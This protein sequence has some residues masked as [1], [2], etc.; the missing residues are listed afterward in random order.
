MSRVTILV[1]FVPSFHVLSYVTSF[2]ITI[3]LIVTHI[4]IMLFLFLSR[5]NIE[6]SSIYDL[7]VV[8]NVRLWFV[9]IFGSMA[10]PFTI[11]ESCIFSRLIP[12]MLLA[13]RTPPFMFFESYIRPVFCFR[14]RIIHDY[15]CFA[16][17]YVK[18]NY[19]SLSAF[20]IIIKSFVD[21]TIVLFKW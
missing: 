21:K 9:I 13:T 10:P 17:I 15:S 8:Y 16:F 20:D 2:M 3:S 6:Y 12:L 19:S 1:G 18:I 4:K 5:F 7:W 14:D 11:C